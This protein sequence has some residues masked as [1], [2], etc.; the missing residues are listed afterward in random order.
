M[1][2]SVM[3]EYVAPLKDVQLV[4]QEIAP[5]LAPHAKLARGDGAACRGQ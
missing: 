2:V 1:R 5:V 4:L 3:S